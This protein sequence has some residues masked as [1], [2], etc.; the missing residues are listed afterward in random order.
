MPPFASVLDFGPD[1]VFVAGLD[2]WAQVD[3][4]AGKLHR[5]SAR[6]RHVDGDRP[7][8]DLFGAEIIGAQEA[9]DSQPVDPNHLHQ[10][11]SGI[12]PLAPLVKQG[13]NDAVEPQITLALMSR[14]VVTSTQLDPS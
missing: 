14:L 3:D 8:G 4:L 9:L 11:L 1:A 13:D 6:L 5:A 10:R 12:D 2:E 7:T